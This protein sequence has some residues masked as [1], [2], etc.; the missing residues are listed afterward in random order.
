MMRS[1]CGLDLAADGDQ[2]VEALVSNSRTGS[3][4]THP[5]L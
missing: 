1:G 5:R 4:R 3:S 2:M